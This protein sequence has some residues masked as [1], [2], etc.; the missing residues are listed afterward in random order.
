[1]L[2]VLGLCGSIF[3]E[4]SPLGQKVGRATVLEQS[5]QLVSVAANWRLA[6]VIQLDSCWLCQCL[7][8]MSS[9]W[10]SIAMLC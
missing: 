3:Q 2:S 10:Y 8:A 5:P 4:V 9:L 7:T 6:L 1:M